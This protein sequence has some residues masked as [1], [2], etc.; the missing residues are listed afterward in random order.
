MPA[1]NLSDAQADAAARE[2]ALKH[3]VDYLSALQAVLQPK[4]DDRTMSNYSSEQ[5]LRLNESAGLYA[6]SNRVS[7]AE[8][9]QLVAVSGGASFSEAPDSPAQVLQSAN[10][11]IFRAGVHLND[12]NETLSFS[13]RDVQAIADG[14]RPELHEAPLVLGH[15]ESDRPAYGWVKRL[16]ATA[17]GRLLMRVAK[18]DEA[19]ARA[20]SDGR[21]IKRSASF[22]RPNA[23]ENPTPGQWYLRHVGW[24]GAHPPALKG[25]AD[26]NFSSAIN[27]HSAGFL[28]G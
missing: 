26:V 27:G 21:Y 4:P 2:Y 22:Y 10:I 3:G 17:D 15:P 1:V 16:T 9:L 5:D 19:F 8:A 18:V 13:Q 6:R 11:E 23:P 12:G 7:Y 25:L 28:I 24:L 14:Y 20:I